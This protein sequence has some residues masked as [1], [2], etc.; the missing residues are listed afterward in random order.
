MYIP[1]GSSNTNANDNKTSSRK[2]KFTD[3]TRNDEN[4]HRSKSIKRLNEKGLS[5]AE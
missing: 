4:S 3:K 1:T 2:N 5:F